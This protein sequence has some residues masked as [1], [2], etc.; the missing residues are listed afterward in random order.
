M[1][2]QASP[3]LRHS[4]VLATGSSLDAAASCRPAR[5][6]AVALLVG[7]A[8]LGGS[9]T[10]ALAQDAGKAPSIPGKADLKSIK[11]G[12]Y[13]ADPSHTLIGW[14]VSH[15]GFNDYFG[16]FGDAA[17]KLEFDPAKPTAAKVE[18]T[19]PVD[20]VTTANKALTTHLKGADFFEVA[21]FPEAK[22][23]SRSVAVSGAGYVIEGDLSLKGKTQ[24]VTLQAR[25]V[26]AGANPMSK[27]ET[28]GF[29]AQTTIKRSA[30]GINYV[31]PM[32]SDEVALDITVA[33]EKQ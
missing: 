26:G 29:H 21:K 33:F 25:F 15:F 27:A 23:V 24:P 6:L 18:I 16:V 19:I 12:T 1:T 11:A 7:S 9:L 31:V 30:W 32:V 8:L 14:R 3:D 13:Q 20:Q 28:V 22:F 5:R 2:Q 10:P 17:G 4:P